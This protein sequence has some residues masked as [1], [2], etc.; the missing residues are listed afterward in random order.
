QAEDGIRDLIVTGVQTCALPIGQKCTAIRRAFAPANLIDAAEA[1][2]KERLAKIVV[3]NPRDEK[4]KMGA[5]V[6][7]LQRDDVRA[8]I[9]ELSREARIVSGDPHKSNGKGAFLEPIL[10]RCDSPDRA[11]AVH[12]VEAFGPVATLMPYSDI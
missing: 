5:L 12:E 4:T 2:L 6:S 10:L 8:Q 1:A 9:E 11:T 7:A 3:G